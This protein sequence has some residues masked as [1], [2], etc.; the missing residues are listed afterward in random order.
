VQLLLGFPLSVLSTLYE[1]CQRFDVLSA[2]GLI[3]RVISAVAIIYCLRRGYGVVGL[4]VVQILATL[5]RAMAFLLLLPRIAPDVRFRVRAMRGRLYR[6]VRAYSGWSSLNELITESSSEMEKLIIPLLLSVALVTPYTLICT[7][8]AVI[9]M[10]V[11]PITTTFFPLSSAYHAKDDKPRLRD[12][13]MHGTKLVMAISL[14]LA[15]GVACY[16]EALIHIW[17][18]EEHVDIPR[19]VLPLVVAS[20][21]TTAFVMTSGIILLALARVREVF[22][23]TISELVAALALVLV[24]TPLYELAG[25]AAA[26]LVANVIFTF[27]WTVPYVCKLLEQSYAEYL[28]SSLLRPLFA[29]VPALL[30]AYELEEWFGSTE[31]L[32]YL[33]LKGGVVGLVF[34]AVFWVVSLRTQE[35]GLAVGAVMEL[36]QHLRSS[37]RLGQQ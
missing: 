36:W 9:F 5:F 28:W 35:R 13:L 37:D 3:C 26:V 7:I 33:V 24:L 31:S 8:A 19:G 34:L 11:E 32:L 16:G 10:A 22:W 30:V 23:M 12:L 4:V 21:A 17:I 20:F 15:I 1:G 14:P 27:L 25:L 2:V 18:G 6:T 29:V